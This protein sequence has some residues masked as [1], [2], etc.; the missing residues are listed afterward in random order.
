MS[1]LIITLSRNA[2]LSS[3]SLPEYFHFKVTLFLTNFF[4]LQKT[5]PS[6]RQVT[7]ETFETDS[8]W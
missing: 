5:R 2:K 6:V 1:D 3:L 8:G 7:K 4:S